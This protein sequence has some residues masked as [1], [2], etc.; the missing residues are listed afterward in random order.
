[1][2]Q[3]FFYE[4]NHAAVAP[5]RAAS[6]AMRLL[7]RNPLNPLSYTFHGRALAAACEV[8]EAGTRRYEKPAFHIESTSINGER[9]P[10]AR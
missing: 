8:F 9:V 10:S 4:Q 5:A 7:V 3:Y 1:M 2:F 6:E